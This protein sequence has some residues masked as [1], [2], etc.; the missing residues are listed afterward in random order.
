MTTQNYYIRSKFHHV[1]IIHGEL[2]GTS[3]V[4][5]TKSLKDQYLNRRLSHYIQ[6]KLSFL[7]LRRKIRKISDTI[8]TTNT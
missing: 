5:L 4:S 7:R 1:K 3:D 8:V 6:V 2:F